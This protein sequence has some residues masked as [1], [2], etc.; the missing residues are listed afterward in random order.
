MCGIAGYYWPE[1]APG[2]AGLELMGRSLQ[3]RGPDAGGAFI[4]GPVGLVHRRLSIIDL[5][6]D[7]N[8]PMTSACGRYVIV[9]NGE[10][11]NYHE[12]KKELE[13]AAAI[14]FRTHSDTE[15]LLEAF[16]LWGPSCINRFNGMFSFVICDKKEKTLYLVRDR[17][18]IKPLFT[19]Q[20]GHMLA[21][22]SEMK[23]FR[24]VPRIAEQLHLNNAA[25]NDFLHT[26][27]I[28]GPDTIWEEIKKFPAGHYATFAGGEL[29]Y[30]EYWN[31]YRCITGNPMTNEA[32]ALEELKRLLSS[33]VQM[34]LVSDV[35][36]G[37]FLSGGV[38]SSL[39]T[40]IAQQEL[41]GKINT[42]SI[43][44][45]ESA[46]DESKYAR[47][48]AERLGTAHHEFT[49]TEQQAQQLI[50]GLLSI[51]DEPFADSSAIPTL[52]VSA[53]AR[54]HV[55]M[56]LSG[57]GGDELFMGYGA[58]RWAQR[59]HNPLWKV[60]RQPVAALLKHGGSRYKR[61]AGMLGHEGR[62]IQSHI[63]SQEQYLFSAP[64]IRAL[65]LYETDYDGIRFH[66]PEL[67][68]HLN[69]AEIQ[70]SYDLT[71]Y[72]KDDLLVKTD[73]ATMHHS[74]ETRIPLLDYR[75][76]E[77]S[78]NLDP[79]LKFHHK[80]S[81]YLLKKLL[82]SFL[83]ETLFDRP[84][85]G[86]AIPLKLWLKGP[87]RSWMTDSLSESALKKHG[88]V[89]PQAVRDLIKC[90]LEGNSDYLY[91]RIWALVLLHNFMEKNP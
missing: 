44:F 16:A 32:T 84:K 2:E 82:Y 47:A 12:I 78:L 91:N 24:S 40:A 34:R 59:L 29:K 56:T 76:I 17:A 64:D 14:R 73:R 42:F 74:L 41:G 39:V 37:T 87:L 11:Y 77:F 4:D 53:M 45:A 31:P 18:G 33:S 80:T 81:K 1:G 62:N 83:P 38:D 66:L 35:P 65:R 51:Y 68:R 58:Y 25:I 9:Y 27:Y 21:F 79:R 60:G 28:P 61:I 90:Y 71:N 89:K 13:Q 6:A 67:P 10:V 69:P 88:L 36:F 30:T 26:G 46:Y 54:R 52:L 86:F 20:N 70:S 57:D 23:A 8:Q 63:F 3:H 5:S 55:T 43:G 85:Q 75:I 72:L 7:A 22:A 48:V 15:V 19:F 49:V 50:P